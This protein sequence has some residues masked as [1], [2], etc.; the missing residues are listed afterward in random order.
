MCAE[1]GLTF[2]GPDVEHVERFGD[3]ARARIVA[4]ETSVPVLRGVDHA[5]TLDEA[6][7]FFASLRPG[8]G[9]IVKALA[10]GG[11]RAEVY[12]E[13]FPA[14][15]MSRCR[16]SATVKA[17]SRTSVSASAASSVGFLAA[18]EQ[19][20]NPAQSLPN[21]WNRMADEMR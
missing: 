4:V 8:S 6:R 20:A 9:M 3:K 21:G 15:V 10:G 5:V 19:A 14:S 18:M 16:F 2:V 7:A 11:G 13:E 17:A 1:A 12:V